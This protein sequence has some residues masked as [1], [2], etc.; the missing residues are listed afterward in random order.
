M[1]A[2]ACVQT[3]KH[4]Y[5]PCTNSTATCLPT[6]QILTS[7]PG[8]QSQWRAFACLP[9]CCLLP[10]AR[11]TAWL[12]GRRLTYPP[13]FAESN[14][15]YPLDQA[16]LSWLSWLPNTLPTARVVIASNDVVIVASSWS[17]LMQVECTLSGFNASVRSLNTCA[18]MLRNAVMAAARAVMQV[19][20][21]AMLVP[22]AVI[23]VMFP[24]SCNARVQGCHACVHGFC[25]TRWKR[26]RNGDASGD[27]SLRIQASIVVRQVSMALPQSRSVILVPWPLCEI[28]SKFQCW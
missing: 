5:T 7:S 10:A 14:N 20:N 19:S 17:S 4:A 21:G 24:S 23:Q 13:T 2:Q 22:N 26:R 3:P 6:M 16:T 11:L 15:H 28:L 18:S 12:P 27:A 8:C 1:Q 9:T 25:S